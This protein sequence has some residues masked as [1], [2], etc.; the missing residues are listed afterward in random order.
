MRTQVLAR[1]CWGAAGGL[2]VLLGDRLRYR[3]GSAYLDEIQS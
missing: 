3:S 2:G 1:F